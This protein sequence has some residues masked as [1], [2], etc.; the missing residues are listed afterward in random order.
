MSEPTPLPV[1]PSK[2]PIFTAPIVLRLTKICAVACVAVV[3]IFF[4]YR[5][6]GLAVLF[7]GPEEMGRVCLLVGFG[8]WS[9]ACVAAGVALVVYL[10]RLQSPARAAAAVNNPNALEAMLKR[11]STPAMAT[12]FPPNRPPLR[13]GPIEPG[14]EQETPD[15]PNPAKSF[16][17]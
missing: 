3:A 10:P 16:R 6:F 9:L 8:F 2:P 14:G 5:L 17:P 13:R 1:T 7:F 4:S 11:F 12:P 15:A